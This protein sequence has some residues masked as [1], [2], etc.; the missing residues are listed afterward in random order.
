MKRFRFNPGRLLAMYLRLI[1]NV[2]SSL[3]LTSASP[4]QAAGDQAV[5]LEP[6]D[7]RLPANISNGQNVTQTNASNELRIQCD[8]N[9][10]GFNPNVPDCQNA[11]S[12]YKRSSR[13]FT[14][15]ERHSGHGTN[16]FPLPYRL[17][18]GTLSQSLKLF[19]R[20]CISNNSLRLVAD[21]ALCYIE[22]VLID[23]SQGTGTASINQLSDAVYELIL[24]CA[25]RQ[26]K[27]GIATGIG[28][29]QIKIRRI[30]KSENEVYRLH[31]S[32]ETYIYQEGVTSQ[33]S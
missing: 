30:H 32:L 28:T 12:Y 8:G 25:T 18:G 3:A 20:I 5:Q 15:G 29:S 17:M 4:P 1:L 24:Q 16:V 31:V 23:S 33:W 27:G 2:L 21:Q 10:Y 7:F 13:L 26:L 19:T 11:R 14:Y 6:V 9:K 22:P